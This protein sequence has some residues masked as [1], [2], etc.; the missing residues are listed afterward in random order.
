MTWLVWTLLSVLSIV[1]YYFF[2]KRMFNED[3]NVDPR[4][5]G[6]LLQLFVGMLALVPAIISGWKFEWNYTNILWL[7]VVGITYTI[8]PSLYY[9]G[10]KHT[11]LS[12][13]TT[14]DASGAI[15]ALMLGTLVLGELLFWQKVVG[16]G[17]ILLGIVIVAGKSSA[18]NKLTKHETLLLI[19]PFFYAIGAIADKTLIESSNALSYLALSFLVAGITMTAVNIPRLKSVGAENVTKP[20]FLKIV[21]IN[22][23]FVAISGYASYRAYQLGG[24]VSSMYPIMQSESVVVPFMA[25]LVFGE[26]ERFAHKVIGALLAFGGVALLG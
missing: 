6:G 23:V 10:L 20:S 16:A 25:M 4:F 24:E 3:K 7:V 17:L 18:L 9:I 26:R 5:Y 13:T 11:H 2:S 14:L 1:F 21:V 15:Y 8:G 22:A 12:V 19:A